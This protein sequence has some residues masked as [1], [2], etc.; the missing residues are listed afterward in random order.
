MK[1]KFLVFNL[2]YFFLSYK[3]I[4]FLFF[5]FFPFFLQAVELQ[6]VSLAGYKN[7]T[8]NNGTSA[9]YYWKNNNSKKWF[10]GLEGG[11][12]CSDDQ[13]CKKKL[14]KKLQVESWKK[15]KI[16]RGMLY[17]HPSL[18]KY[19]LVFLPYCSSDFYAGNHQHNVENR[20]MHFYG[21]SIVVGML[22]DLLKKNL[23][24]A[25]EVI[26]AGWSAGAIGVTMNLDLWESLPS[27]KKYFFD[28]YWLTKTEKNY[29]IENNF[30]PANIIQ[31][32]FKN[33]P[34]F[35]KSNLLD[36]Y[37]N[38]QLLREKNLDAMIVL[39]LGNDF[40][41]ILGVEKIRRD[42]VEDMR[43]AGG[44][45]SLKISESLPEKLGTISDNK[46]YFV[47]KKNFSLVF[48][49]WLDKKEGSIFVE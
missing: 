12:V 7:T 8:C 30:P 40:H 2:D 25:E 9:N 22:E 41:Q 23:G 45:Y 33:P 4:F 5:C 29:F 47:Q 14:E 48:G 34:S 19:N 20:I 16:Q 36:C 26:I 37:P 43:L 13:E 3:K 28:G 44:G 38:Y 31:F 21:R 11:W 32:V 35:C 15:N 24:N 17:D 18:Q 49:N 39:N 42:L 1:I 46:N 10:L 6:A 27:K